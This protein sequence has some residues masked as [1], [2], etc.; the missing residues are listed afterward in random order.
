MEVF[1]YILVGAVGLLVGVFLSIIVEA[2]R[3]H[4]SNKRLKQEQQKLLEEETNQKMLEFI[5]NYNKE[6]TDKK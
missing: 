2:I 3:E 4:R 6:K 1:C 5:E